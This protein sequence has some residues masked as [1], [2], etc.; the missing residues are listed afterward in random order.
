MS[1]RGSHLARTVAIPIQEDHRTVWLLRTESHSKNYKKTFFSRMLLLHGGS[2]SAR[3]ATH[4]FQDDVFSTS[5]ALQE[6]G[7]ANTLEHIAGSSGHQ[8][9]AWH[10]SARPA[11]GCSLR[12]IGPK[13]WHVWRGI[14]DT[15]WQYCWCRDSVVPHLQKCRREVWQIDATKETKLKGQERSRESYAFKIILHILFTL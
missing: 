13:M 11:F 12:Q 6:S 3:C 10:S 14:Y 2:F 8:R 9:S 7:G 4:V 5:V 1:A 15:I